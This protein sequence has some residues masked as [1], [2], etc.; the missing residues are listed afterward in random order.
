MAEVTLMK[1]VD[2]G[3]SGKVSVEALILN[4]QLQTTANLLSHVL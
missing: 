2:G 3:N 4:G 1:I